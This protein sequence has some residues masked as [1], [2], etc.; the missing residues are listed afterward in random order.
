M[1]TPI[2]KVALIIKISAITI[3]TLAI[4]CALFL[5]ILGMVSFLDAVLLIMGGIVFFA[6]LYGYA[7]IVQGVQDLVYLKELKYIEEEE[8]EWENLVNKN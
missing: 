1:D 5:C 6:F 4:F 7:H 2:C 8:E 3:I